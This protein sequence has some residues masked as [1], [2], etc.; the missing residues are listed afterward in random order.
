MKVLSWDIG[1]KN[2][3]YCLVE[4]QNSE[5]EYQ[6]SEGTSKSINILDWNVINILEDNN[7]SNIHKCEF[8]LPKKE[9]KC[10]KTAKHYITGTWQTFCGTHVKK[11][12]E[13]EVNLINK[14]KCMFISSKN[15]NC[16]KGVKFVTD[17]GLEGYCSA[18]AK[19]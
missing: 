4:Y 3:A 17:N 14:R 19:K 6:N 15:K 11:Y 1:I 16:E 18:H 10:G 12:S 2:L 5:V 13:L 9:I 7:V 8:I